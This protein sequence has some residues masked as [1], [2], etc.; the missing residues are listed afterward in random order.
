ML[1]GRSAAAGGSIETVMVGWSATETVAV[2]LAPGTAWLA[3][4]TWYVPGA[5]CVIW[6]VPSFDASI[7]R[8][9]FVP[10]FVIVIFAFG[11]TEPLSSVTNP[12][13]APHV[14]CDQLFAVERIST[15]AERQ[16]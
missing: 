1:P 12:E 2:T 10:T 7:V 9:R 4:T 16:R 3:A 8:E 13:I 15:T 11:M 6:K 5:T 14:A